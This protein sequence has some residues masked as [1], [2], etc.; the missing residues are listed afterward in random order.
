MKDPVTMMVRQLADTKE[1]LEDMI[2][3]LLNHRSVL[4]GHDKCVMLAKREYNETITRNVL[5][6]VGIGGVFDDEA[7]AQMC[8]TA[9][10][11]DCDYFAAHYPTE[12]RSR[13]SRMYGAE[14]SV[15]GEFT[16][17]PVSS[18]MQ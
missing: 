7:R 9:K 13:L 6:I 8:N 16:F 11:N 12:S 10:I 2:I 18:F 4:I 3:D 14:H 5:F 15:K 17:W 1:D